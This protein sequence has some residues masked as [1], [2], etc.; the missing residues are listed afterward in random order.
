M[1]IQ[2]LFCF[3]PTF[4]KV[5]LSLGPPSALV[6]LSFRS[7]CRHQ[8]HVGFIGNPKIRDTSSPEAPIIQMGGVGGGAEVEGSA[9]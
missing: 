3:T 4:S 5:F 7:A 1:N 2:Q 6:P 8:L 9:I